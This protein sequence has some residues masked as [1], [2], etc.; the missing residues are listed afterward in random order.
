MSGP[1][2]ELTGG[3]IAVGV[4][5]LVG[6][7]LIWKASNAA[8]D[9]IDRAGDAIERITSGVQAAADRVWNGPAD[10]QASYEE[11]LAATKADTDWNPFTYNPHNVSPVDLIPAGY[12]VNQWGGLEKINGGASGSW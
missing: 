12:R 9:A 11:M 4:G 10:S 8:G 5:L 3:A 7:L 1:T 2:I 6:G